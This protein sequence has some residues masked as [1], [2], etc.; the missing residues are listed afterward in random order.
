MNK[1]RF[2]SSLIGFIVASIAALIFI[3]TYSLKTPAYADG[4]WTGR[5]EGRNGPIE[6][7]LTVKN[8]KIV[9]YK[10]LF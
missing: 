10:I 1:K 9:D 3:T 6:I 2:F 5:G 4:E 8:K 7:S